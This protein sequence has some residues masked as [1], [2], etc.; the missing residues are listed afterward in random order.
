MMV[1]SFWLGLVSI[2]SRSW[3]TN[4]DNT[5]AASARASIAIKPPPNPP[6]ITRTPLASPGRRPPSQ[7]F[8]SA[9]ARP[10]DHYQD[11]LGLQ[12]APAGQQ[13]MV[14]NGVEDQVVTL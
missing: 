5:T 1:R 6:P 2:M 11:P 12:G 7:A 8:R 9:S 14:A 4:R 13:R 3:L 10:A